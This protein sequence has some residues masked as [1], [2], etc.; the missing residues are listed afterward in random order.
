MN[1]ERIWGKIE[2][3]EQAAELLNAV[4]AE[5]KT[6]FFEFLRDMFLGLGLKNVFYGVYDAV[7]VLLAL[8]AA[9]IVSLSIQPR[10]NFAEIGGELYGYVFACSPVAYFVFFLISYFKEKLENSFAVKMTCRY[11][12]LHLSAFRMFAAGV[13]C[14]VV[15]AVAAAI[16]ADK[17]NVGMLNI[18][19]V[20]F[21]SLFLFA[22]ITIASLLKLGSKGVA[23]P[24][25]LIAISIVLC[26]FT[27]YSMFLRNIPTAAYLI[28]GALSLVAYQKI[29][30]NIERKYSYVVR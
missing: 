29:L 9:M 16:M 24:A 6:G 2:K 8:S 27:E 12:V 7:L 4:K 3:R 18:A 10:E 15:N 20:S 26:A 30:T 25:G 19:A 17:M 28:L 22:L 11:T 14:L 23:V 13:V 5:K 21:S 1:T